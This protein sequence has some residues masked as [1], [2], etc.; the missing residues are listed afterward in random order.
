MQPTLKR[1]GFRRS[2]D[3]EAGITGTIL[4]DAYHFQ[5]IASPDVIPINI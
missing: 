1:E 5:V 2:K 4:E 3:Q